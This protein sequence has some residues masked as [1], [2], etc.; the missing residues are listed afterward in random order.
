MRTFRI[1]L[2]RMVLGTFLFCAPT[3]SSANCLYPTSYFSPKSGTLPSKGAVV[4]FS[5]KPMPKP[6]FTLSPKG[7]MRVKT[8]RS[9]DLIAYQISYQTKALKTFSI[10]AK[11]KYKGRTAPVQKASFRI[12]TQ[13]TK[14]ALQSIS[15]GK[16]KRY[17]HKWACSHSRVRYFSVAAPGAIAYQVE[18]SPSKSAYN[19][20]SLR[21]T[22]LLPT[23]DDNYYSKNPKHVLNFGHVS[24]F[25][26]T[27]RW[28]HKKIYF[29]LSALFADGSKTLLHTKPYTLLRP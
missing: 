11:W 27:F 19:K 20:P 21:Q 16:V 13:P 2:L 9:G 18:W 25:G 23:N 8:F 1:A 4:F 26:H 24:C 22:F 6:N 28:K 5:R 29:G 15:I 12:K 17:V 3:P 7:T 14:H 10:T